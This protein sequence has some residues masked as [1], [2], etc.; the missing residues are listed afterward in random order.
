[1]G[2]V[3]RARPLLRRAG[4]APP[5]VDRQV[6]RIDRMSGP[7]FSRPGAV[8]LS[9]FQAAPAGTAGKATGAYVVE[10]TDEQSLATEVVNRSM[11]AVVLL[12]VWSPDVPASVQ[13]NET[14]T[15]LADEF[16]GRFLLA[17]LDAKANA[18][19]VAAIGI[20]NVPLVAAALRG[21]LAPLFQESLPEA[22]MRSVIQQI[23]QAATANGI[24][25]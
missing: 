8:D 7:Q 20:P 2:R 25:G 19:L 11:A 5:V 17:T 16:S 6:T 1:M 21:Q 13:L 9:A 3:P 18:D 22:E 12:S 4:G 23:L 24:T 10:I 14:L 15:A